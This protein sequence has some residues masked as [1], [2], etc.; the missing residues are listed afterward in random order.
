M[1]GVERT[2]PSAD[3]EAFYKRISVFSLI[4]APIALFSVLFVDPGKYLVANPPLFRL[5]QAIH[6]FDA[7]M[8][9]QPVAKHPL[10]AILAAVLLAYS[11]NIYALAK[12]RFKNASVRLDCL[13]YAPGFFLGLAAV[14]FATLKRLGYLADRHQGEHFVMYYVWLIVCGASASLLTAGY[15]FLRIRKAH[16]GIKEI[17]ESPSAFDLEDLSGA[18]APGDLAGLL[19]PFGQTW[20]DMNNAATREQLRG[21]I[22]I[23]RYYEGKTPTNLW[24]APEIERLQ[25]TLVVAPPGSGKT[26]SIALPWSRELPLQGQ[27]VFAIDLKGNMYEKLRPHFE[28]QAMAIRYFDPTD[29]GH[30][31]CWNPFSELDFKDH[32]AFRNGID[33]LAEAIFGE[34]TE[35]ENRYFDQR[36]LAFLRAGIE[37]CAYAYPDPT[38]K[39]LHDMFLSK[40][41]L[42]LAAEALQN[43]QTEDMKRE[44]E[45]RLYSDD[46]RYYQDAALAD[47]EALLE[48][49]DQA[50]HPHS[51]IV[52][53]VKNKLR[54][55]GHH[56]LARVTGA[57]K[58][59]QRPFSFASLSETPTLFVCATPLSLG[60]MGTSIAAI[61]VRMLHHLMN[62]RF[63]AQ[64]TSRRLFL[65]L[66][67]FS[68]LRM[69]YH[70]TLD[71]MSTSREAKCVSVIFLQDVS[72]IQYG[73]R[74]P[75][76]AN[77]LD[78]YFLRGAGP[79]TAAWLTTSLGKRRAPRATM[80]ESAQSGTRQRSEGKAMSISEDQ[81]PVL[82]ER[83]IQTTG[84]LKYGAWVILNS[85]SPKPILVNLDRSSASASPANRAA[86]GWIRWLRAKLP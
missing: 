40:E 18:A 35:G 66:D 61:M 44:P 28:G 74:E 78:R 32:I 6:V 34:M 82:R 8:F 52:Q 73:L 77:C 80:S 5:I 1:R 51:D 62:T 49:R 36:D 47:L 13:F 83:E 24:V 48:K 4:A 71:F 85:Y 54:P 81:V 29:H 57:P 84:G 39:R 60:H 17:T 14:A 53:G 41:S 72:Q 42:L 3:Q 19:L 30:S 68:K 79:Q 56:A 65:V 70:Q 86:G 63:K 59:G 38:L 46:D 26:F 55:F 2:K 27:S 22:C 33:R 11:V 50:R 23:G 7:K 67:E 15:S 31:V 69:G 12:S 43:R 16:L 21:R 20:P 58:E 76:L 64:N 37:I 45:S 75:I 9:L 10:F 25:Q